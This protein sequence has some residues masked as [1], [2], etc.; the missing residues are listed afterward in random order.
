[1]SPLAD[2]YQN[3]ALLLRVLLSLSFASA[4]E[5]GWDPTI[6]PFIGP[7]GNRLFR[8]D[9]DGQT[10][11]TCKALAEDGAEELVSHATRVWTVT[12]PGSNEPFVLKDVWVEDNCSLEHTIYE[13][14][15]C[16]VKD[17]Y[18]SDVQ[19]EVAAHLLTPVA[20]CLVSVGDEEDHT[21]NTMMRGFSPSFRQTLKVD[22]RGLRRRKSE[23]TDPLR[24]A[25]GEYMRE[26]LPWYNP[27]RRIIGRRHYRI[28][29]REFARTL[30]T[31]RDFAETFT[32]LSDCAKS[33][34]FSLSHI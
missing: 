17:K 16:D 25:D 14:I 34:L 27:V 26:A 33:K 29:F 24:C 7:D 22:V 8:I 23:E 1:M 2:V 15:L 4:E 13:A 9:V 12:R 6:R 3:L 5:L 11:E 20:H 19:K 21:T 10:F 32:V 28:V 30:H 31:V 18:G